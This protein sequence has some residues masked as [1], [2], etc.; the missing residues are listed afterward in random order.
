MRLLLDTHTFLWYTVGDPRLSSVARAHIDN[1]SNERL[2]S[3]ASVWEIAIKVSNGKLALSGGLDQFIKDQLRRNW[4]QLFSITLAH[5]V[6]VS[7]LPFYHRD[8]FDRLLI[9]Q[10][11]EEGICILGD[12][13][14]FDDYNVPRI[15]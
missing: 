10:A 13:A 15:W 8:P 12:D 7:V 14:R 4:I 9:A 5:I 1:R 11:L 3:V 2:L 6:R